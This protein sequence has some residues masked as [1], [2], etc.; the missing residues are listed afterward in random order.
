MKWFKHISDS[1]D[2]PFIF[3]LLHK[4]GGDGYLVFFGVLEIYS[5]EFKTELGWKLSVT[6]S[7]LRQKLCKRQSTLVQKI[8]KEISNS[9]KWQVETDGETVEIF[10][11]KFRDLLDEWTL[12]K[13]SKNEK[14]LGSCSG[15]TPKKLRADIDV[16]T[17]IDK[18]T[19]IIPLPKP[20]PKTKPKFQLPGWVLADLWADFVEMRRLKKKPLTDGAKA[21]RL[22]ELK[23]LVDA[24][25]D[26]ATILKNT[27]DH[28]WDKFYAPKS[29][30]IAMNSN[31]EPK[32]TLAGDTS[33]FEGK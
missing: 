25:H 9:G 24:G 1:L 18:K 23:T 7:Y 22:T 6:Q 4:F 20:P 26:Q 21:R 17:D 12:R 31:Y 32:F 30:N 16:D 33:I 5:R 3:S 14:P 28:S 29:D 27:I 2:D 8:L 13:L 11:P 19:P 10:I 15:V